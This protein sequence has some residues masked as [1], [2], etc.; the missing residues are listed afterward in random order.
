[1][2]C[3]KLGS[4]IRGMS[5]Q[6]FR[7]RFDIVN[8]FTPEEEAEPYDEARLAEQA[9]AFEREQEAKNREG[10]EEAKAQ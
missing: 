6:E 7:K 9:E 3:A 1:M 8:D 2:S 4:V 5:I 10:H